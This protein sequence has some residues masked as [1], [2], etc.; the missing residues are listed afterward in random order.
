MPRSVASAAYGDGWYGFN[1]SG[2]E[3]AERVGALRDHCSRLGRDPG[4]MEIAV[5][6]EDG[7]PEVLGELEAAG[8]TELVLVESPPD[9]PG[10]ARQWVEALA[11]RWGVGSRGVVGSASE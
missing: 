8:V 1:L 4:G 7:S 2:V 3:V 10:D 5:S 9:D 11:Q 6:L